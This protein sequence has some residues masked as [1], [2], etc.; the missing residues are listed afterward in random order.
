MKEKAIRLAIAPI[1][2]TNDDLPELGGE[3]PFEQ[4]V[5]EMALAGYEGSEV[6]NKYPK[7]PKTLNRAL[8]LRGLTICNAWFSSFLTTRPYKE[9]EAAFI[10]HRDFLY[11]SG[12]RVIGASE[13]GRSI[14]GQDKPVF[15]AKPV[16]T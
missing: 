11:A 7:D 13:Q 15:D 6:G 10:K 5:S 1:G 9:V 3:I 14:Q 16:F 2:W 8:G 12:A 4:C